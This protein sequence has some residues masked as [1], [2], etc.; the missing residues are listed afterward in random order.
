[1]T[2]F[3]SV[4]QPRPLEFPLEPRGK[5][6]NRQRRGRQRCCALF[7]A[8][9]LV[10]AEGR[11]AT[12]GGSATGLIGWGA[13]RRR[14]DRLL[15]SWRRPR[16]RPGSEVR[17]PENSR[18]RARSEQ[19][20]RHDLQVGR[21]VAHAASRDPP[22]EARAR[23]A[24]E[25]ARAAA[26]MGSAGPPAQPRGSA[27]PPP[28]HDPVAQQGGGA[29]LCGG[30][31][32][33]AARWSDDCPGG[34]EQVPARCTRRSPRPSLVRG[35]AGVRARREQSASRVRHRRHARKAGGVGDPANLRS[36]ADAAVRIAE[37]QLSG[38]RG[39][40]PAGRRARLR[41]RSRS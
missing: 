3:R 32:E 15:G 35:R 30:I 41:M 34:G 9:F 12:S 21:V 27:S 13:H 16:N 7:G 26:G 25:R 31:T 37:E 10:A 20:R 4:G 14:L 6:G 1:M 18:S 19:E 22:P 17:A 33:P 39:A 24:V 2:G 38:R 11:P 40:Q 28:V 29:L 23:T 8:D 36:S 5:P